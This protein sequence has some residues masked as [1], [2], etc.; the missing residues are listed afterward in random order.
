MLN[1][2]I[3][4]SLR[5]RATVIGLTLVLVATGAFSLAHLPIDA[6]PDTTPV[7]VQ[8]NTTAAA[9]SAAEVEQQITFPVEQAIGGLKGLTEVRSL[10]KFGL[11]QVT[12]IFDDATDINLARQMI[13]ERLGTVELPEGISPPAMG[14][15][16]TGLGEVYHYLVTSPTLGLSEL[17]TLQDWVIKPQLR[18]VPGVA[19]VN[20][21][22][23]LERQY[24][25]VVEPD[26]LLKYGLTLMDVVEA[27]QRNNRN[28]GGGS[29]TRAGEAVIVQGVGLVTSLEEIGGIVIAAVDGVPVF[30]R[31]VGEVI[32]GHEIRRG[33]VT[34]QGRGE[35][36]LG[37]GFMRMGENSHD[38][39][40]RLKER[41]EQIR[42]TLPGQVEV[43]AVYDRTELVD[44][45]LRTV[46]VNLFEGALL[47]VVVLFAFLG[48]LRAGLMVAA[49]IPLSML[50]AGSAMLRAGIAGSLMSLGAIDFGLIVDS[51]VI[52]IENSV[53]RLGEAPA[54]RTPLEVVRDAAIEVRKPTLFGELIIMIVYLPILTLE[55]IEGKLFAPM[56][57]TVLFALTGSMVL[58]LTLMPV[59]ASLG[60]GRAVAHREPWIVRQCKR[61]Y[62]PV[63]L[64]VL[65]ARGAVLAA[66]AVGLSAGVVMALNLGSVFIP[67]LSEEAIVVNAVRLAGVSVEESV[68]YGTALERLLLQRFPDEIKYIWSRTGS[69]EVATDPMGLELTDIFM[70]LHPRARWTRASTQ[71]ELVGQMEAELAGMPAMRTIFAQPIELRVNEMI[72]GIR[73][74]LGVKVFG[75]DFEQLKEIARRVETVLR[76]APGNSDTTTEQLTGQPVLEVRLRQDQLARYGV[77]ASEVLDY[78]S[79]IGNV[80][81]GEIRQGQSRFPLAVR[82]PDAYRSDPQ[83]VAD[84]LIPTS[85]GQR[86]P[87]STL[88]DLKIVSGPS[89][90]NREWGKRRIVVQSNVRGRDVGGFVEEVQRRLRDELEPTLPPGYYVRYGGQFEHLERAG[91]RL[92]FVVPL[93][94]GLICFLLYLTYRRVA[95]VVRILTTLPL[96]AVGGVA[97]LYLR[98]MPF[99]ISAGVGFVAMSGV[100]VLGDMVFVSHLRGM[101]ARGA[102]WHDAIL[103]TAL[104]RLRPVLMTG[105]VASLGFVPMALNTGVGAE[106]QRPLA[107]VVIGC[108]ITSTMLTLLVL[109]VLYSFLA[110]AP[111]RR[112]T[113]TTAAAASPG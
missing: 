61:L 21:W 112:R 46:E 31:D 113:P 76:S 27:L 50:F 6:F 23:G 67:R 106:V 111:R 2:I 56:A 55:G 93:A 11:S 22:G 73:S 68:R 25:V 97:A 87:L 12:V 51:S 65:S 8:I 86:L 79:A 70:T 80:I 81:V 71:E 34:F 75:D 3:S 98:D 59:L 62:Q 1:A 18:E 13:L 32:D 84:L 38:V 92:L 57:L 28:V 7:Q 66:A 109:P 26:K 108:V 49:A 82:L 53:R 60:L 36:V 4:W 110:A 44:H 40:T 41:M 74:D 42:R 103:Q 39:T 24:Q 95:D 96:S 107:T 104:T 105:L 15:V 37:L 43:T 9:L 69:A 102:T 77:P 30:I 5:H 99:S 10:S 58:S 29:I 35:G 45:V 14:P 48:N 17:R 47:V 16:A 54:S 101:L 33:A 90:I 91:T 20:S 52:M 63:L 88:A 19:E 100:A 78:V 89:T 64:R 94:L 72:A 83:R 85:A